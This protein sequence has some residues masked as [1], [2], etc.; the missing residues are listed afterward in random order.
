[1][2]KKRDA[3]RA[4]CKQEFPIFRRRDIP[5]WVYRKI[6]KESGSLMYYANLKF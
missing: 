2:Y 4:F 5:V 1:M 6:I 3:Q